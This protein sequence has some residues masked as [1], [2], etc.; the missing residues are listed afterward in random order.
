MIFRYR[1][2]S[3]ETVMM[4]HS[5]A[6]GFHPTL[7]IPKTDRDSSAVSRHTATEAGWDE[8]WSW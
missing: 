6:K 5:R 4:V 1:S 2:N 8:C 3:W 7:L